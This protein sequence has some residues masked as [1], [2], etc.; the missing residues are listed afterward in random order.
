MN[1]SRRPSNLID[2]KT[3]PK[4]ET[5]R[6]DVE[7]PADDVTLRG[8]LFMPDNPAGPVP[9]VVATH[10]YAAVKEQC[11]NEV[12]EAFAKAG[13]AA[14]VYDH[15]CLGESDGL[16]RGHIDPWAQIRDYR[17]AI[18]FAQTIEGVDPNRIGVWGTSYSGAHTIVVTALDKRVKAGCAQV[19]V[20]SG[21]DM[22]QRAADVETWYLLLERLDD[23][24]GRWARGE[25]PTRLAVVSTD[26]KVDAINRSKR[27]E[28]FYHHFHAPSWKNELTL[29][30]FDLLL[31]YDTRAYVER[32]DTT[33][34]QFVIAQ[35][36]IGTPTDFQLEA[37]GRIRGPKELVIIP[38]DH[39]TSYMEFLPMAAEAAGEFLARQLTRTMWDHPRKRALGIM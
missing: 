30:S 19:P 6:T 10:G 18:T 9:L 20:I 24:R 3:S 25:E 1:S 4:E 16:P 21:I 35:D 5:L 15:R 7:F 27:S 28:G 26:P 12:G 17:H 36:D 34:F 13:L 31:E 23:E 29:R 2:R 22:L 38:G 32:L 33:P 14:L 8:W 11:L 37:Y 39:Y